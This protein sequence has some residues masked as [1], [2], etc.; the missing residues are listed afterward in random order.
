[1]KCIYKVLLTIIVFCL[2]GM[3]FIYVIEY[4]PS[5]AEKLEDYCNETIESSLMEE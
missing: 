3:I 5:K 2:M 4:K 1:M